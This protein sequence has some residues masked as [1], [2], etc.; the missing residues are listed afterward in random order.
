[1]IYKNLN[2]TTKSAF[3]VGAGNTPVSVVGRRFF[4]NK[5]A[6]LSTSSPIKQNYLSVPV[7][8]GA[9]EA[10]VYALRFFAN[11]GAGADI[12][13]LSFNLDGLALKV[14]DVK[15][16]SNLIDI[17]TGFLWEVE[18]YLPAGNHLLDIS[19]RQKTPPSLSPPQLQEVEVGG[20]D[21]ENSPITLPTMGYG[22]NNVYL[23]FIAVDR[24][25]QIYSVTGGGLTW[26]LALSQVSPGNLTG[27]LIYTASGNPGS[28]F[29][30]TI[31]WND[32]I[33]GTIA[34]IACLCARYSNSN[35]IINP[36]TASGNSPAIN[37]SNTAL[38]NNSVMV[39]GA[40]TRA[41]LFTGNSSGFSSINSLV[42]GTETRIT[43]F[44][45]TVL[46]GTSDFSGSL[47][48]NSNWAA[49]SLIITPSPVSSGSG[50]V[51]I[52]SGGI[53]AERKR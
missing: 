47:N 9:D 19:I 33:V 14:F 27:F 36:T 11:A 5:N 34:P 8:I 39:V 49:G 52:E 50:Y 29:N 6:F 25:A 45:K 7:S 10:G 24:N 48:S 40:S 18:T 38:E 23:L 17:T 43:A 42:S 51:F 12:Q 22:E 20:S 15:S 46:A 26:N 2:G 13:E 16:I 3:R 21:V 53:T 28:S 4:Q 1:M 30:P 31:D 32:K 41:G 37:I 44:E 35:L